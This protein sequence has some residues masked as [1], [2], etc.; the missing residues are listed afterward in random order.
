M[1]GDPWWLIIYVIGLLTVGGLM[2]FIFWWGMT[3]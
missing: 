1:R 2:V 3:R